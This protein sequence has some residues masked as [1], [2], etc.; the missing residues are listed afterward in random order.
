MKGSIHERIVASVLLLFLTLFEIGAVH[1]GV[2]P[3]DTVMRIEADK[4][5]REM[6]KG[7]QR[8]QASAIRKAMV[9]DYRDLETVRHSRNNRPAISNNVKAT[10][11]SSCLCLLS[12][13]I[14][15]E[16]RCLFLSIC[17]V[18]D[19]RLEASTAVDA[20]VINLPLQV[21]LR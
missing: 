8:R 19:G 11:L 12:R 3:E 15:T 16:S 1:N 2:L 20:F 21:R 18:E 14:M 9:G 10:M 5:L 17:M 13:G 6:P 7:L 4:F